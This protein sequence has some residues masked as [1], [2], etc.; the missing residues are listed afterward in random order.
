MYGIEWERTWREINSSYGLTIPEI[1]QILL[2]VEQ[3]GLK[4]VL[5]GFKLCPECT[6]L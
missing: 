3:K 2:I 5:T 6:F 4:I 1:S